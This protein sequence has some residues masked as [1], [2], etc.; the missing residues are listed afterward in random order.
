MFSMRRDTCRNQLAV[1]LDKGLFSEC[2][3]VYGQDQA[4]QTLKD[5]Y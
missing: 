1:I 2:L 5:P 4:S 3:I